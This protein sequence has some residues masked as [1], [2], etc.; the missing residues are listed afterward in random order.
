MCKVE[1]K[2]M[3]YLKMFFIVTMI[4]CEIEGCKYNIYHGYLKKGIA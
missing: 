1:K 4:I 3:R 2:I